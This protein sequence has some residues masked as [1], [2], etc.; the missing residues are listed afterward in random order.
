MQARDKRG[1][2]VLWALPVNEALEHLKS[3][4]MGLSS[5]EAAHIRQEAGYNELLGK[6]RKTW[7]GIMAAQLRNPLVLV[8]VFAAITSHFLGENIN[9]V[10]ILAIVA[11]NSILGFFQEF[12]AEKTLKKLSAYVTI[13]ASVLRDGQSVQLDAKEIV[14]GDIIQLRRGDVVPVDIRLISAAGLTTDESALTGVSA[15]VLKKTMIVSKEKSLPQY[16]TNVVFTG[17]SVNTGTGHG[18][19]IATGSSTL[20]G[21]SA[22]TLSARPES[23]FER[24]INAFSGYLLKITIVM[25]VFIFAESSVALNAGLTPRPSARAAT[26]RNER[27]RFINSPWVTRDDFRDELLV[28]SNSGSDQ[29]AIF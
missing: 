27:G 9:S 3:S 15:P 28:L 4:E 25:T 8:L 2:I 24:G 7:I 19:A 26:N 17:T 13:E 1:K 16:L 23:E 11:I 12:R 29:H 5:A 14:P 20:F 22:S 10:V 18:V 21:K 6:D